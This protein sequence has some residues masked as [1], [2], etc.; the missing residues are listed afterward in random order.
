[1]GDTAALTVHMAT[2][3]DADAIG[4]LSREFVEYLRALGDHSPRGITPEEYVR[5]G[6]G[7]HRAF[8]GFVAEAYGRT[9]GYLLMSLPV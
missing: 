8:S 7:E 9:V 4:C 2:V 1:M 5:D 6:F 3:D